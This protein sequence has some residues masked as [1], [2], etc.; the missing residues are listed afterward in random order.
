MS[1]HK[2]CIIVQPALYNLYYL[3]LSKKRI[4]FRRPRYVKTLRQAFPPLDN[5]TID[6]MGKAHLIRA[7]P[8]ARGQSRPEITLPVTTTITTHSHSRFLKSS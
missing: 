7:Q 6:R 2:R 3:Y 8:H 1:Y 4:M 5:T